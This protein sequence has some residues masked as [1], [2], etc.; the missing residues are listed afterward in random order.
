MHI[1]IACKV[2]LLQLLLI[3]MRMSDPPAYY[4]WVFAFGKQV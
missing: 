4:L 3:F 1:S 2:Y